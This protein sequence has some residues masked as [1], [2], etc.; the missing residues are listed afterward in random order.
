ML[1]WSIVQLRLMMKMKKRLSHQISTILYMADICKQML[2]YIV[3]LSQC[4]SLLFIQIIYMVS[5][6]TVHAAVLPLDAS[7]SEK[8]DQHAPVSSA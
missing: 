1:R 7:K 5:A 2:L 4:D 3:L 8:G 6:E